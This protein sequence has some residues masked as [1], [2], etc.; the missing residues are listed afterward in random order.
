M[1]NQ[2]LITKAPKTIQLTSKNVS[3]DTMCLV[4]Y[5]PLYDATHVIGTVGSR[6]RC[7]DHRV[8]SRFPRIQRTSRA[9]VTKE[10]N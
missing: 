8:A 1:P 4:T 10:I 5:L 2:Q 7:V 9:F 3:K 6:T